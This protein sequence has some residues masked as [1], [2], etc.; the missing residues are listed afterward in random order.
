METQISSYVNIVK[1]DVWYLSET[2]LLV[3]SLFMVQC[4]P[5]DATVVCSATVLAFSYGPMAVDLSQLFLLRWAVLLW[6]W[7]WRVLVIYGYGGLAACGILSNR[8]ELI[9]LEVV[10]ELVSCSHSAS[11]EVLLLELSMVDLDSLDFHVLLQAGWFSKFLSMSQQAE[12]IRG[13]MVFYTTDLV[14]F[15]GFMVS[16]MSS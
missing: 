12:L 4:L 1:V 8:G 3:H 6:R 16:S 5:K 9:P 14:I 7:R 2:F 13:L 11:K 15:L 10:L